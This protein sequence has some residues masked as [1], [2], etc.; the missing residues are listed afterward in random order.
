MDTILL[1]EE[2]RIVHSGPFQEHRKLDDGLV[3]HSVS[4]ETPTKITL[5]NHSRRGVPQMLERGSGIDINRIV[6]GTKMGPKTLK[7]VKLPK[8]DE[9]PWPRAQMAVLKHNLLKLLA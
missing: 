7:G 6:T 9:Y 5:R 8:M 4:R 3:E 2:G 1:L